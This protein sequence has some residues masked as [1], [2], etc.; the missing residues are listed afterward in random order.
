MKTWYFVGIL[1]FIFSASAACLVSVATWWVVTS[2]PAAKGKEI[3]KVK[4]MPVPGA[5]SNPID[6]VYKVGEVLDL[7]GVKVMVT[8][9]E[10]HR[11]P[12]SGIFVDRQKYEDRLLI[13]L[14]IPTLWNNARVRNPCDR[15][16]L[17]KNPQK[18]RFLRSA[19]L[20]TR[21]FGA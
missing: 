7:E 1:G 13:F 18:P 6:R 2:R 3:V 8:G 9:A 21:F 16:S 19:L 5:V 15:S 20:R 11:V 4:E 12:V 14:R 17:A 10:V